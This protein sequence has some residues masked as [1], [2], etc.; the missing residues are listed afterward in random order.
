MWVAAAAAD[1]RLVTGRSGT[2][3]RSQGG[4]A[5]LATALRL[6]LATGPRR[7][8]TI[9]RGPAMG[10]PGPRLRGGACDA[11]GAG[12]GKGVGP[13]AWAT[14][15]AVRATPASHS[16]SLRPGPA[17]QCPGKTRDSD[18]TVTRPGPPGPGAAPGNPSPPTGRPPVRTVDGGPTSLAAAAQ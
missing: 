2:V 3:R 14:V 8:L 16:F 5:A 9:M 17:C 18:R 7:R 13:A 12:L 10:R 1:L 4:F 11:A 6:R 15:G